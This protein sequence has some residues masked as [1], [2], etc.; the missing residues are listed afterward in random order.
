MGALKVSKVAVYLVAYLE[1]RVGGFYSAI[2]LIA[3]GA[4]NRVLP[5]PREFL[6]QL[7][8]AILQQLLDP[9]GSFLSGNHY[10]DWGFQVPSVQELRG[11]EFRDCVLRCTVRH[12]CLWNVEMPVSLAA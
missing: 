11:R 8:Q 5:F 3:Q 4:R 7:L 9:S 6:S 10:L 1:T 12:Q 2:S